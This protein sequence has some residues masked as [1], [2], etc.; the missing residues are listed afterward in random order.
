MSP[1]GSYQTGAVMTPSP[2]LVHA[3][4]ERAMVSVQNPVRPDDLREPRL[5]CALLRPRPDF[6]CG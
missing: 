5:D 4:G 3:V 2:S 6:R 1:M